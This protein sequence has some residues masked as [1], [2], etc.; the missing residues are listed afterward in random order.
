MSIAEKKENKKVM[1]TYIRGNQVF[2]KADHQLCG[3]VVGEYVVLFDGRKKPLPKK[4]EEICETVAVQPLSA[5]K[6]GDTVQ[7]YANN[8]DTVHETVKAPKA[9]EK[10]SPVTLVAKATSR[11]HRLPNLQKALLASIVL[12]AILF[13]TGAVVALTKSSSPTSVNKNAQPSGD[14]KTTVLDTGDNAINEYGIKVSYE[15][16]REAFLEAHYVNGKDMNG[17][18]PLTKFIIMVDGKLPEKLAVFLKSPQLNQ[19]E[20][21]RLIEFTDSIVPTHAPNSFS[22]YGDPIGH[23]RVEIKNQSNKVVYRETVNIMRRDKRFI[24][25]SAN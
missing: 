23:W 10:K 18:P 19:K 16:P 25:I 9:R 1:G 8:N 17:S 5:K 12:V 6:S 22:L 15:F 11:F 14:P 2:N 3:N 7:M 13:T 4:A 21:Q 24:A 20:Q